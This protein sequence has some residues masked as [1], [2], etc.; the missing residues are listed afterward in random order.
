[1]SLTE[2]IAAIDARFVSGNAVPVER[3]P[4]KAEEWAAIRSELAKDPT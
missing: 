4:I 1:M 2:I 3:A